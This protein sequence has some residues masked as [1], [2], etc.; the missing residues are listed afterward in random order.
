MCNNRD[1]YMRGQ[2][3]NTDRGVKKIC[4]AVWPSIKYTRARRSR[5]GIQSDNKCFY[6][7]LLFNFFFFFFLSP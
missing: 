4:L 3:T 5:N 6:L 2:Q 1:A 7:F